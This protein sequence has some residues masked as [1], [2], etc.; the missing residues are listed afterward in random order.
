MPARHKEKK[1]RERNKQI[2]LQPDLS[3]CM[4]KHI[5]IHMGVYVCVTVGCAQQQLQQNMDNGT[6]NHCVLQF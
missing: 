2:K 4:L 6:K 3:V 5:H 1:G